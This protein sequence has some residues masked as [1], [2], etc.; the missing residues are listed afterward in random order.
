[1]SHI[2]QVAFISPSGARVA[3]KDFDVE[4]RG[5]TIFGVEGA[6]GVDDVLVVE[7]G[8]GDNSFDWKTAGS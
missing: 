1:M 6:D 5:I 7:G 8:I 2:S 4:A 3:F